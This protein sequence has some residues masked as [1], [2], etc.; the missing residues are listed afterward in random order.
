MRLI[1]AESL[2]DKVGSIC[3]CNQQNYDDI[4]TFMHM[5]SN[6]PTIEVYTKDD[7]ADLLSNMQRDFYHLY[8]EAKE[9]YKDKDKYSIYGEA[10]DDCLDAIQEKIR[11]LRGNNDERSN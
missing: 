7:V 6:A 1:D 9:D 5:I 11:E 8:T 4:G 2:F 3:P 10:I